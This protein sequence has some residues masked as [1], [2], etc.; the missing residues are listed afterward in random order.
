MRI[1]YHNLFSLFVCFLAICSSTFVAICIFNFPAYQDF[2]IIPVNPYT[3][4]HGFEWTRNFRFSFLVRI[5]LLQFYVFIFTLFLLFMSLKRYLPGVFYLLLFLVGW[6]FEA[7]K[8]LV[9]LYG[10]HLFLS[11]I[12]LITYLSSLGHCLRMSALLFFTLHDCGLIKKYNYKWQAALFIVF[13]VN[14][15]FLQ[16]DVSYIYPSGL[17]TL[18]NAGLVSGFSLLCFIFALIVRFSAINNP[19]L[20]R[21]EVWH[22]LTTVLLF[23]TSNIIFSQ[24]GNWELYISI[25]ILYLLTGRLLYDIYRQYR[26]FLD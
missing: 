11:D 5:F 7:P 9:P 8:V 2:S 25:G 13:L 6:L 16:V 22:F 23:I 3:F 24:W 18:P 21:V 26:W 4:P 14:F 12:E 17:L 1:H 15:S 19:K 20:H 10:K